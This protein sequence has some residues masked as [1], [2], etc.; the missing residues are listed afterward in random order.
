MQVILLTH[1]R[2]ATRPTNTGNLAVKLFPNYCQ[3]VMWSRVAPSAELLA[4]LQQADTA[5]LFPEDDTDD[6]QV[7]SEQSMNKIQ[8]LSQREHKF[9]SLP[10][11]LVILDA[12]WQEA[13]KMLR[14]SPYLKTAKTF[15]LTH[16]PES[17]FNL[18]RNQIEGGLCTIECIIE[19]FKLANK[20]D[21][22]E[23]LNA[24]FKAFCQ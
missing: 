17:Q 16:S 24:A 7:S 22:A 4:K 18:R 19:L 10:K 3:R 5:L 9:K 21:E 23:R 15:S 12:T 2:E 20:Q 13:R 1:E 14:Q 8:Q 6:T 11:T